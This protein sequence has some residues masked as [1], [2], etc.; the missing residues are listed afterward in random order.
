MRRLS[1]VMIAVGLLAL[2]LLVG[3]AAKTGPVELKASDSSSTQSLAAGQQLKITLD[4]NPTT[5]YQW[6]VDGALPAQLEMVGE[7]TFTA[8]SG[9]IGSGG[10]QV[11]TFVGKASGQGSLRLKYWRSFEPTVAPISTFSVNIDVR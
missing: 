1:G 9:A 8:A 5:G 2:A 7:P 11:W 6:A 3:C 10:S 4:A